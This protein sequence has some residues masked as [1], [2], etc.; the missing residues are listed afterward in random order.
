MTNLDDINGRI[1]ELTV[2]LEKA[3]VL[4]SHSES[5]AHVE[6]TERRFQSDCTNIAGIESRYRGAQ[7]SITG[8]EIQ[9][10]FEKENRTIEHQA[11]YP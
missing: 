7:L 1:D 11:I 5:S 3:L 8:I 6:L 4:F 10:D 2:T 9:R